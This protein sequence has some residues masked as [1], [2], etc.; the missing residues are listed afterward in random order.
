MEEK[1]LSRRYKEEWEGRREGRG[2]VEGV[3]EGKGR[4]YRR[5]GSYPVLSRIRLRARGKKWEGG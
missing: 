5:V 1:A 2:G 4:L 3:G